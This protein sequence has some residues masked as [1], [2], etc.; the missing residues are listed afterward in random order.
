M[1][2][3]KRMSDA[4]RPSVPNIE[5]PQP[6]QL[7]NEEGTQSPDE[8][9]SLSSHSS[10]SDDPYNLHTEVQP[11]QKDELSQ[12][13]IEMQKMNDEDHRSS[14]HRDHLRE[15]RQR[16]I[17]IEQKEKEEQARQLECKKMQVEDVRSRKLK[18][19]T[20][21]EREVNRRTW[22]KSKA[23]IDRDTRANDQIQ[24]AA[25]RLRLAR[26]RREQQ[27]KGK[28]MPQVQR[29]PTTNRRGT[30][31]KPPAFADIPNND[32]KSSAEL[33]Q[34]ERRRKLVRRRE[35]RLQEQ[36]KAER[37]AAFL[38]EQNERAKQEF[39]RLLQK[40][41]HKEAEDEREN[42]NHARKMR[43]EKKA[44]ELQR[45]ETELRLSKRLTQLRNDG[46]KENRSNSSWRTLESWNR[47]LSGVW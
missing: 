34:M 25:D 26:E 38:I 42:A 21:K 12:R 46:D 24:K 40:Q 3:N 31:R 19:H 23:A 39:E 20:K 1:V 16:V 32:Q 44:K 7:P 29:K 15:I 5:E 37:E 41:R 45:L 8:S 18:T 22:H 30:V 47:S 33:A 43:L 36:N 4:N 6:V 27:A 17:A 2:H 11:T 13:L 9:S 28:V 14:A 35:S 10:W